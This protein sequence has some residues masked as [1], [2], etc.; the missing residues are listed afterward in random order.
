MLTSKVLGNQRDVYLYR[1]PGWTPGAAGQG[2][3]GAV[4]CA[5]LHPAGAHPDAA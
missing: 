1:P 5:C 4:R 3:A 2:A